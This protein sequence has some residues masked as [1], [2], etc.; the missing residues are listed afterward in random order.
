[1]DARDQNGWSALL[2]AAKCGYRRAT[3]DLVEA[4]ADVAALSNMGDS[5]LYWVARHNWK[6]LYRRLTG[7]KDKET[8]SALVADAIKCSKLYGDPETPKLLVSQ[9]FADFKPVEAVN[10]DVPI[11]LGNTS[12]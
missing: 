10:L 6:D 2:V 1:M 12:G 8:H 4:G 5:V 11:K 7:S 9:T 3:L